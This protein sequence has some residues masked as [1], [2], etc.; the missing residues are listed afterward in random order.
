[1][2]CDTYFVLEPTASASF[3]RLISESLMAEP[4]AE[5]RVA[6]KP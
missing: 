6:Q 2:T 4:M 1:M 5:L 3:C